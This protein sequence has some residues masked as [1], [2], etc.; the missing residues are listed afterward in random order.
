MIEIFISIATILAAVLVYLAA[1]R[2][3]REITESVTIWDYQTALHFKNGRFVKTLEAGKFRLW[4]RGHRV[5][6]YD[7]RISE[8]V[9]SGQE[10]IT[11][12]SATL[13]LTAVAQWKIADA[14]KFHLAAE[15]SRQALYT[16]VQL[17]LRQVVGSLN[18]DTIL[19]RKGGFGPEL[20]TALQESAAR[21]LG[22]TLSKVEIRDLMLGADL[23]SV[24]SSVLTA[25]KEA[26]AKLEKARGEAAALRT[27]ANA[28]RVFENHPD[29]FRLRYLETLREAGAGY[30]NQLIVG[31][32]EEWMGL[33]KKG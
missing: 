13:K 3:L 14:L 7:N 17:A 32:P 26:L 24:Y 22:I 28:A 4:G 21:D 2:L 23:K 9:V 29:L 18:L 1:A 8:L 10:L 11:A 5:I 12:D 19:E 33:V 15:D 16:R 30:G 20:A 27:L 31:V 25:R 6:V